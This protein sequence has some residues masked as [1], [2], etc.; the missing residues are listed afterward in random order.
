[1]LHTKITRM[2]RNFKYLIIF[3]STPGVPPEQ[4]DQYWI[5]PW[6]VNEIKVYKNNR[7]QAINYKLLENEGVPKHM[8]F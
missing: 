3:T 4:N 7:A 5:Q 2:F 8:K 6:K 1:M